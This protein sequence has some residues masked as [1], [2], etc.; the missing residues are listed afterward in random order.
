[1]KRKKGS[2][3]WQNVVSRAVKLQ[4]EKRQRNKAQKVFRSRK[5]LLFDAEKN[6]L[7]NPKLMIAFLPYATQI[8]T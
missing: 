8:D 4:D 1:M 5:T 7:Q 6:F 2:D 3:N